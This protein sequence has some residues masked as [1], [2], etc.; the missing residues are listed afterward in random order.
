MPP[1]LSY[2]LASVAFSIGFPDKLAEKTRERVAA[3]NFRFQ[4]EKVRVTLSAGVGELHPAHDT[5]KALFERVD[6]ALY[7]AK[8]EG[9]NRV[10][11][12]ET[13]APTE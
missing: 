8:Q 9:R 11:I 3:S 7:Q 1:G 5:A 4:K 12:A 10:K 13:P 6:A 2:R